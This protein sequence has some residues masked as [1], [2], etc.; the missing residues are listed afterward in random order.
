VT[1]SRDCRYQKQNNILAK[2]IVKLQAASHFQHRKQHYEQYDW[3]QFET[4]GRWRKQPA[5]NISS[6]TTSFF[7]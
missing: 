6:T 1:S 2:Q 4:F 7:L 3:K 5:N